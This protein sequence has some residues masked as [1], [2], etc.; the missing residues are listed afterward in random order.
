MGDWQKAGD[1]ASFR[2]LSA[3]GDM[4]L[5]EN[6]SFWDE[7]WKRG[8]GTGDLPYG[9]AY[10]GHWPMIT[11]E[12][13]QPRRWR[14]GDA[15]LPP[16]ARDPGAEL[17]EHL[18]RVRVPVRI[19]EV[20]QVGFQEWPAALKVA[21]WHSSQHCLLLLY[22]DPG[23]GKSVASASAF[24]LQT[25]PNWAGGAPDWNSSGAFLD[26]SELAAK[27]FTD[28]T[29]ARVEYLERADLVVIDELGAETK[30]DPW[31]SLLDALVNKRFGAKLRTVLCT[32]LSCKRPKEDP[33]KPSQFEDRY[34]PRIARRVR[35]DG[36]VFAATRAAP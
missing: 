20:L 5:G 2:K 1:V 19:A 25:K 34:G 3:L 14:P 10:A 9:P 36:Q 6:F 11:G 30:S 12:D 15:K 23:T 32:N 4:T 7:R 21:E 27:L 16:P 28:E 29:R 26:A 22:G 13:G 24:M 33:T 8:E 18:R 35:E 17:L 31:L